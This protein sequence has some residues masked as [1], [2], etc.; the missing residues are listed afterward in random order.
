MVEEVKSFLVRPS[1]RMILDLTAGTGGHSLALLKAA[2]EQCRLIGLDLD[3]EALEV[4]GDRLREFGD[5]V[6]L[7]K[8][9]FADVLDAVP[10]DVVGS[11]DAVIMDCG[12]SRREIVT[13]RRGFSFDADGPL[14]MRFDNS[15]GRTAKSCLHGATLEELTEIFRE[16]GETVYARRIA[17][18]IG[19][20]RDRGSM[21]STLDLAA[22]IKS[23][24]R[25][26]QAR[27][28][29]R[30]FL[31]VRAAVNREKENLAS[32]IA[33][34]P[35]LLSVGG[36]VGVISYHSVEDRV[37]KTLFNRFSGKRVYPPCSEV[38]SSEEKKVFEV[39][40][41]KPITPTG[42]EIASNPSAR[43]A[44]LRVAEKM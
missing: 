44:K 42:E 41:R 1:I 9:N 21:E 5:R 10:A 31:A 11:A 23:V 43:S 2:P 34:M 8:A 22:A 25:G 20:R 13:S 37:V 19:A 29:A 38:C 6:T 16:Y 4:A 36:R 32:A 26:R 7:I 17:K 28:L 40:T 24:V 33:A 39:L 35:L 27:S 15:N 18:A 14:D 12:I 3:A 30:V